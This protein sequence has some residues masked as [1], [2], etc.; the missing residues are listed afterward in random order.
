MTM[1][2]VA[3]Y[4]RIMDVLSGVKQGG[5]VMDCTTVRWA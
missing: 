4:A 3:I 5:Q 1:V 2:L